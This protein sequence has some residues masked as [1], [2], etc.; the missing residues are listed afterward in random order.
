MSLI[1][2]YFFVTIIIFAIVS[3]SN[4]SIAQNKTEPLVKQIAGLNAKFIF[5]LISDGNGGAWIGAE[6]DG[7]F[8]CN[9]DGKISQFTTKNGLG[10]NNGYA[11]AIDKLGRLW[12]GHLHSGVSVFNGKEWKNYDVADGPI[13]ERIFDIEIC[14]KDGDVWMATSAGITRY[15]VDTDEWE[16]FTREDGLLEDQASALAFKN[17]G[18]LIVGTQCHGLAIFTRNPLNGNYRFSNN[19]IAPYRFGPNNC[20]PVPLVPMGNN[21]PTH[22]SNLPS[23]LINDI[24]VTKNSE[25]ETIWIATNAGLVK[26]NNDFSKLDFWRGK[27]YADKVR[28]LYGGSPKDWKQ[29]PKEIMDQLLPEDYLTCLAEDEQG[30]IWI[31]TRQNGFAIA[32]QKTRA[33]ASSRGMGLPDNFVTKILHLGNGNYWIGSNGGGVVMPVKPFKLVDRKPL[34]TRFNNGKIFSVAQNNFPKLPSKIKP[35]TIDELKL[36][37]TKLDKLKTPLPK[38]YAAYLGEDWKTQGNWMGRA[39][40]NW[41]IMCGASS[42]CNLYIS[43]SLICEVYPF[44]GPNCTKNDDVRNWVHWISTDN[45]RSLWNPFAGSRRQSEWDDHGEAYPISVDGPDV[46][47]IL[48]IR[49]EGVFKVGM[50]FF[51]KDGHSGM[52]R[53]RDYTIEFYHSSTA[54]Y[55]K[56]EDRKTLAKLGELTVRRTKQ[57][58]RCRVRDFW[59]GTHKQFVVT[60]PTNY[61]VKI[62][63]NYSYNTIISAVTVDKLIGKP[64]DNEGYVPCMYDVKYDPPL[65]P[66][67]YED[68]YS[69][70]I[71]KLWNILDA[72]YDCVANVNVQRKFRIAAYQAANSAADKDD[73]QKQL[74]YCLKW[75]L[76]QWDDK[77]RKE[78]NETMKRAWEALY[79]GNESIRKSFDSYKDGVPA[80][81]RDWPR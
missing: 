54:N 44:I 53:L 19:I 35:P 6:D 42:P 60:G 4:H 70:V 74:A 58:A 10:D 7:V 59:G 81:F 36:M 8:H 16:H 51:N 40:R 29:V 24:I 41:A 76:N 38:I 32:D 12:V 33:N 65:F 30:V 17:D 47:Y 45:P 56:R 26:L 77:Q 28:G 78:W 37:Q 61:I 79:N 71:A 27:D 25:V 34:N 80:I 5:A 14:P 52:N 13:G 22:L 3:F 50:Y 18:T 64:F 72:K 62:R 69:Y 46:W 67:H 1:K 43:H 48:K 75:R 39:F 11:L 31:G 73:Y 2:N 66:K 55:D 57:L 21:L 20:S 15:K 68:H 9:V 63:R 23:N 49:H